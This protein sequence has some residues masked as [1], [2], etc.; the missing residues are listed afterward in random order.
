MAGKPPF[1][2]GLAVGHGLAYGRH[3]GCTVIL[4]PFRGAVEVRGLATGTRELDALSPHHLVPRVDAIL[5]TGGS[6]F[7]LAAAEGVMTWLEGKGRGY[8][9][10][11]VPVPIVPA[12]V[13]FDLKADAPRPDSETG[14][15][16]CVDARAS[17]FAEGRIG[18]GSGATV[19]KIAGPD[20]AM[21]GGFGAWSVPFG[22]Y[23]VGALVV[24]NALGDV[25][26]GDGHIVAGARAPDGTFL[27]AARLLR[28]GGVA[29]GEMDPHAG[30]PIPGT[31]TTLA[32]VATDM[33][34]SKIDLGR[35][36]R[37]AT[38][39]LARRISP[40]HTPFDG[41]VVFAVSTAPE[42]GETTSREVL[43]LGAVAQDAL[44]QA[45]TRA[46]TEGT[47]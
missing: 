38:N 27:N 13:I 30:A 23:R 10:G 2:P 29:P 5:L 1:V 36:A 19:G 33:P 6:A 8:D 12:A 32:V 9:T 25:L 7:G 46:V 17:D 24:V 45:I 39:A 22:E 43:S 40:V 20:H 18:V 31:N 41:D 37:V 26:D 3:T 14:D 47:R 16:A 28:S 21:P 42:E 44:E 34:L 15:A 11:V 35:V 4:G